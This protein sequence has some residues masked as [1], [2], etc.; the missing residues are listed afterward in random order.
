[1]KRILATLGAGWA[2]AW[3]V[4]R[5]GGAPAASPFYAVVVIAGI[6]GGNTGNIP[7]VIGTVAVASGTANLTHKA[8]LRCVDDPK[9]P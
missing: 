8:C 3:T 5:F 2:V 1:V 4:R 7:L 6:A 9:R